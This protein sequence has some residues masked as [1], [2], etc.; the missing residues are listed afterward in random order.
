MRMNLGWAVIAL[1]IPCSSAYAQESGWA[2]VAK[3]GTEGIGADLHRQI[4]PNLLNFRIG[5]SFFPYSRDFSESDIDYEGELRLA[6]VPVLLDLYPFKNWFRLEGGLMINFNEVRATAVPRQGQI[7]IGDNTYP[8]DL[9]GQLKGEV[10]FS[11]ASP[12][13]GL[14]FSNPI[15]KGKR[16]GVFL[17]IG[18][19][20]HGEGDVTLTTTKAPPPQLLNDLQREERNAEDEIR[21]LR[22]FP[23][24]Q[25]GVSFH[26]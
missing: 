14:G 16:W 18:A 24:V 22:F 21:K 11:R 3:I 19:M 25:F 2:V 6:A 20:Y 23:I 8:A 10:K 7:S 1:W 9:F 4:V 13:F 5:G 15:K 12:Y 26:F 17:D